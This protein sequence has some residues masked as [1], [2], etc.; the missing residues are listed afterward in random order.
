MIIYINMRHLY[1]I[2]SVF[3]C[4][5]FGANVFAQVHTLSFTGRDWTNQ[6]HIPLLKVNV[7]DLD[8]NWEKDLYYP[9]TILVLGT[10]GINSD[11]LPHGVQLTQ[12]VPNP[13][14]GVTEFA[15]LLPENHDVLVEIYDISGRLT[16]GQRFTALSA[17]THLF[18]AALASPQ[19]YLLSAK[20]DND[21]VTV[22]MVNK[23]HGFGNTIRYLGMTD[24][25]EDYTIN[26]KND[27]D[28]VDFPFLAG[29]EMRY[30]GYAIV[31]DSL[32]MSDTITIRQ[33]LDE[34]IPLL[35]DVTVP[36]VTTDS[37]TTFTSNTAKFGG[38]VINTGGSPVTARG[39]C[40]ST[41]QNPTV[42]D[43]HITNGSDTGSFSCNITN[44]NPSTTY[45][46]RA[47]ATNGVGTGYGMQQ[48]F[49]TEDDG[50]PCTTTPTLTD[51]DGNTY[52]TVSIGQQCWMRENL[53][54]T[55]YADGTAI[56]SGSGYPADNEPYCFLTPAN[57][58]TIYGYHYNWPAAMNGASS[59][60]SNPS[61][62][63]GVC[64]T[65]WHLPSGTEWLELIHY[66]GTQ[67]T[68][69]CDNDSS[70][71]SKALASTEGW[72]TSTDVCAVGNFQITNNASGFCAYPADYWWYWSIGNTG[73]LAAFYTSTDANDMNVP[74]LVYIQH[75]YAT[76]TLLVWNNVSTAGY[77]IRCLRDEEAA[78]TLLTVSTSPV[79]NIQET[80]AACGGTITSN[81]DSTVTMRGLCWSTSP[82][83]TIN[84]SH[85]N[86]GSGLGSF[87]SFITGLSPRTSY[88]VRAYAS[89]SMGT[90]Y[91]E[92][93][94]FN[95]RAGKPRVVTSAISQIGTTDALGGGDVTHNGGVSVTARGVCW[96]STTSNPTIS[97]SHTTDG[98]GLGSY[99]SHLTGLTAATTYYVRA[100]ATNSVGTDYGATVSFTTDSTNNPI[101]LPSCPG[102]PTVT[103]FEGNVYNTIQ[104]GSQCWM[105]DNLRT[106][107]YSDGSPIPYGGVSS[108][109]LT[110]PYYYYNPN[111]DTTTYG[112]LYNW[113]AAMHGA[114]ASTASPSGVQGV[115]PTGWHLPSR[116]E[117]TVLT[118]Y[119]S[120]QII[121]TCN[122]NSNN[123]AKALASTTGW[124]NSN[125]TCAVGNMPELNNTTGFNALPTG[126]GTTSIIQ[127]GSGTG[128][129]ST[130][131]V[132]GSPDY[133]YIRSLN[134]G[135]AT[136]SNVSWIKNS[137]NPV[138]CILD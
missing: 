83:P 16:V 118:D 37:I 50:L 129:W 113:T 93:R 23:G 58:P 67:S 111:V 126:Y 63:Q 17:G 84:D 60:I 110:D 68:L 88:Y 100:Y 107:H 81:G 6:H 31:D 115:C 102:F 99:G 77:S 8:R 1:T 35:F 75:E 124:S 105:R 65:G 25:N 130:S 11:I 82:D 121:Y 55:H 33:Y 13:F 119:V 101:S 86:N 74:T 32:R 51:Y 92:Q 76:P 136:M 10:T 78:A 61:G 138:R 95:T 49:T 96:S 28:T 56:P 123:I 41:S 7:S 73:N 120:N 70:F 66:M 20:M 133:A 80:S 19:T 122:G 12:N 125:N 34:I 97:N 132:E 38:V 71:I 15:I 45:Y 4:V 103:D 117:W 2:L 87:N 85:T 108:P 59:S 135:G 27:R 79:Y 30:I 104:I 109:S 57:V 40:W 36:M 3:V 98:S 46:V 114:P 54:T 42:S 90:A 64:P 116:N 127:S 29:D 5:L 112:F 24:K 14:D 106:K 43:H 22:K 47:Y 69:T 48:S 72:N 39:F 26:L 21:K 89:N 62:V 44:L 94:R 134:S 18:Q 91:G 9:D 53:R 128:F 137:G 131:S 52:N